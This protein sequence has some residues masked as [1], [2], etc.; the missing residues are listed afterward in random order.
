[1]FSHLELRLRKR[2]KT[3]DRCGLASTSGSYWPSRGGLSF[4]EV[5][6]ARRLPID[7]ENHLDPTSAKTFERGRR[8]ESDC[9]HCV[10]SERTELPSERMASRWDDSRIA[11]S[12]KGW[13][14]NHIV[15]RC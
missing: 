13:R 1:M 14:G 3:G 8:E 2:A 4:S 11:A 10:E 15:S 6:Q 12:S 9:G 7:V 5:L